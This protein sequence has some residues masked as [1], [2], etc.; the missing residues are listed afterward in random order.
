[1]SNMFGHNPQHEFGDAL[2]RR[3]STLLPFWSLT[4][5]AMANE[6]FIRLT[7]DR[8]RKRGGLWNT[9]P[10]AFK[11]WEAVIKFQIHGVGKL[12]ADGFAF[13]IVKEKG[14]SGSLYGFT[15]LFHGLGVAVDTYDNDG[16]GDHPLLLAVVNDGSA[17]YHHAHDHKKK[18]DGAAA[19]AEHHQGGSMELG[20]CRL[21]NIRNMEKASFLRI[22]YSP[23]KRLTIEVD[24]YGDGNYR[25]CVAQNNVELGDEQLFMGF[26]AATGDLADNHDIY[27]V[28]FRNLDSNSQSVDSQRAF[29]A[30]D[31]YSLS[32]IL[33]NIRFDISLLVNQIR[34]QE[35]VMR[36]MTANAGAAPPLPA[37]SLALAS[38]AG[39]AKDYTDTLTALTRQVERLQTT[40]DAI[41]RS[42]S[43]PSRPAGGSAPPTE[44]RLDAES[45]NI[46]RTAQRQL[47][48][49][50]GDVQFL[51]QQSTSSGRGA[52]TDA[53]VL[54]AEES[55]GMSWLTLLFIL[56]LM[57]S[58]GYFAFLVFREKRERSKKLF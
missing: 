32:E 11:S 1:M 9:T 23:A 28:S 4:G 50:V 58:N 27:G 17:P 2:G 13:W 53:P 21:H 5:H 39:A 56:G 24:L 29:A 7:E 54:Q 12:G 37:S 44:T 45:A 19:A 34:S 25:E 33:S 8:Q 31:R 46:L 48:Q 52:A 36:S 20:S 30:F 14:Q 49:L 10:L 6:D 22:V 43:S 41:S 26:T 35:K 40:A 42:V 47:V 51:K 16:T 55:G 3:L 38:G 57:A 18:G 15:D